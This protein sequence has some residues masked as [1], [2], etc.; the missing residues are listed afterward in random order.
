M[1]GSF[2]LLYRIFDLALNDLNCTLV[3]SVLAAEVDC[4][5]I[6]ILEFSS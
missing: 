2:V 3:K 5:Q 6:R 1:E 4:Q